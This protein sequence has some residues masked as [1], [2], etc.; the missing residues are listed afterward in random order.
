M[1]YPSLRLLHVEIN[2]VTVVACG[3]LRRHET[4][5]FRQEATMD[6]P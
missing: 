1:L 5:L 6:S 3:V 4:S 2:N